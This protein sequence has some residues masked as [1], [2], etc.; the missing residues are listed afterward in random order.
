MPTAEESVIV[1]VGVRSW[2]REWYCEERQLRPVRVAWSSDLQAGELVMVYASQQLQI[3]P[4]F[5]LSP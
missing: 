4:T 5:L 1:V 2:C 3:W